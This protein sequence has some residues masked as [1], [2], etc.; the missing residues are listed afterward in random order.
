MS[1]KKRSVASAPQ[2]TWA[3]TNILRGSLPAPPEDPLEVVLPL[4]VDT[5]D[6][7]IGAKRARV[8]GP[9]AVCRLILLFESLLGLSELAPTAQMILVELE[10]EEV[11]G[12]VNVIEVE[13]ELEKDWEVIREA[14]RG[15]EEATGREIRPG[16][17]SFSLSVWKDLLGCG[18]W[19]QGKGKF[20]TSRRIIESSF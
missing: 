6:P 19:C 12:R 11:E 20:D 5:P 16:R 18:G 2:T 14:V 17:A 10:G 13:V 9:A 7:E 1:G 4:P 15:G 3:M 8:A